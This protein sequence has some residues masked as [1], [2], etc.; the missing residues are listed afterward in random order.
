[1]NRRIV[2][3]IWAVVTCVLLVGC[4]DL[5]D[6][7]YEMAVGEDMQITTTEVPDGVIGVAYEWRVSAEVKNEP[8]DDAYD[9]NWELVRGTLPEGLLFS[10]KGDRAL[11]SGIPEEV[12]SFEITIRVCSDRLRVEDLWDEDSDVWS[13]SDSEEFTIIIREE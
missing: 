9:Y 7:I 5:A 13:S 12:G 6:G 3:T 11:V 2:F 8:N 1:M 4:E 10:D